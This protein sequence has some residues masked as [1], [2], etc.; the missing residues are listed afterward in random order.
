MVDSKE[1]YKFDPG[2]KRL[3]AIPCYGHYTQRPIFWK[4]ISFTNLFCTIL[5]LWYV[6][7]LSNTFKHSSQGNWLLAGKKLQAAII[8]VWNSVT[9]ITKKNQPTISCVHLTII[10]LWIDYSDKNHLIIIRTKPLYSSLKSGCIPYSVV[11]FWACGKNLLLQ[12]LHWETFFYTTKNKLMF[13]FIYE[14]LIIDFVRTEKCILNQAQLQVNSLFWF[15][16]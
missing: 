7:T 16:W 8:F 12:T 5:N 13:P 3:R 14:L 1:I 15:C 2:V 11:R 9:D 4:P 10:F 6:R